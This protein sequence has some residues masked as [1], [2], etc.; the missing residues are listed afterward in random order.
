M[1]S[2]S[3]PGIGADGKLTQ[4]EWEHR[5]LKG[6]CHYCGL[7]NDLPTPDFCTSQHPKLPAV[8]HATFTI[9]GEPKAISEEVVERPLTESEN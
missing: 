4:E 8:G 6:L 3:N 1:T 7:T 9:T 2:H 5:Q